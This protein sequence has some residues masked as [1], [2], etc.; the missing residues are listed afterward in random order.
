[1]KLVTV[2]QLQGLD[3]VALVMLSRPEQRNALSS[4]MLE[5]LT[6]RGPR[7]RGK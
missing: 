1:M 5:E 6:G 2:E 3:D 7:F 4:S